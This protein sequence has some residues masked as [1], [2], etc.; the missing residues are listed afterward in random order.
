VDH[1]SGEIADVVVLERLQQG[2]N[3]R[4]RAHLMHCKA[5]SDHQP[6]HRLNDLYEVVGQTIRSARWTHP[7][8]LFRE[9]AR[10][11]HHR[12]S[13]PVASGETPDEVARALDTWADNPPETELVVWTVQPGLSIHQIDSWP[14]GSTLISAAEGWSTTSE[15]ASFRVVGS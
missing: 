14:A 7:D 13:I 11:W 9:L 10:R 15:G 5:S 2:P 4:V 6:G 1:G 8:S 12:P 3:A